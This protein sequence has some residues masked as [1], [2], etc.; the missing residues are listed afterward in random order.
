MQTKDY[1]FLAIRAFPVRVSASDER[2][3][4]QKVERFEEWLSLVAASLA[5]MEEDAV[6]PLPPV[7]VKAL[8]K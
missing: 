6:L 2:Q 5:G 7:G 4:R 8:R 3:A 1:D